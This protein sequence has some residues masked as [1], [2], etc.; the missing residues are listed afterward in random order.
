MRHTHSGTFRDAGASRA[1]V[2]A[3][4]QKKALRLHLEH[5]ERTDMVPVDPRIVSLAAT[6]YTKK[7][8]LP[9]LRYARNKDHPMRQSGAC[10]SSVPTPVSFYA[11]NYTRHRFPTTRTMVDDE[12]DR[13]IAMVG[14]E[15]PA[16][17]GSLYKR[18]FTSPDMRVMRGHEVFARGV[19]HSR[20]SVP[21]DN[22]WSRTP[23]SMSQSTFTRHPKPSSSRTF[24]FSFDASG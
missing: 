13:C 1:L 2:R 9:Q 14:R 20:R 21:P 22:S 17:D 18:S 5:R 19:Q 6:S 12:L 10:N 16:T 3:V 7:K 24:E 4:A 23:M 11:G 15:A 8:A